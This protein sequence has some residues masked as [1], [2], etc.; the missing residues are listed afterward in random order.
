MDKEQV[1]IMKRLLKPH[2]YLRLETIELFKDSERKRA[3]VLVEC[4]S[5]SIEEES[6]EVLELQKYLEE[7]FEDC[8]NAW[9]V[10]PMSF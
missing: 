5:E 1:K 7:Q 6:K 9:P 4:E 2:V 8:Y 10:L 3:E